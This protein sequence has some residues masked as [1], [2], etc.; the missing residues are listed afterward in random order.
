MV[1]SLDIIYDSNMLCSF[2]GFFAGKTSMVDISKYIN[3]DLIIP[4]L[5]PDTKENVFRVMAEHLIAHKPNCLSAS[6]NSELLFHSLMDR[7]STQNTGLGDGVGFP[8]ARIDQCDDF[9]CVIGFCKEGF[10][11]GSRDGKA[12]HLVCM[13]ISCI[14]KPYIILQVMADLARLICE[15]NIDLSDGDFTQEELRNLIVHNIE[16]KHGLIQAKDMMRPVQKSVNVNDSIQQAARTMHLHHKDILPV[17]DDDGNLLG[18]ISCLDIFRYGI[19]DFFN[20]LQT[21]SFVR[22]IDPFEKYFKYQKDLLVR[23]IYKEEVPVIS[24]QQTLMEIIFE[25]TVKNHSLLFVVDG[26]KLVGLIDRFSIIDKIL[27]F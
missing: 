1:N 10:D 17:L 12:C 13:M 5:K 3:T 8:H 26:S 16:V 7:E 4:N 18:E 25:M 6:L 19:P 21:V 23:D 2:Y 11:Y 24:Q 20:Q 22:H 9:C 14:D 27:F 15:K